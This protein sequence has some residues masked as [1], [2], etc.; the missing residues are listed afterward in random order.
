MVCVHVY[1]CERGTEAERDKIAALQ[2]VGHLEKDIGPVFKRYCCK[3]FCCRKKNTIGVCIHTHILLG[4]HGLGN[5][6]L[7]WKIVVPN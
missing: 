6:T 3:C 5:S 7:L 1:M 2:M 4:K